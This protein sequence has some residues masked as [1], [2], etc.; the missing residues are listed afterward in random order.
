MSSSAGTGRG[1]RERLETR[2]EARQRCGCQ[3]RQQLSRQVSVWVPQ[4]PRHHNVR[5]YRLSPARLIPSSSALPRP[6]CLTWEEQTQ[7]GAPTSR[8]TNGQR[9]KNA[10][11]RADWQVGTRATGGRMRRR[12]QLPGT[13]N[14]RQHG[15]IGGAGVAD[16]AQSRCGRLAGKRER[17]W[18][19]VC[20][21]VCA[22]DCVCVC[23]TYM[24]LCG[25]AGSDRLYRACIR[26]EDERQRGLKMKGKEKENGGGR[27]RGEI[28]TG[29]SG[30]FDRGQ[31]QG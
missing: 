3:A 1:A 13:S 26:R 31:R 15:S 8:R 14:S 2:G 22:R 18:V 19:Y 11:R 21:C 7:T 24:F 27:G 9:G 30:R 29:P 12:R 28:V 20:M 5:A 25:G 6:A 23:F 4:S 16:G 17:V 10:D